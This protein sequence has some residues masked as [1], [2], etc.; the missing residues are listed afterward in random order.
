MRGTFIGLL[1]LATILGSVAPATASGHAMRDEPVAKI[2]QPAKAKLS[3]AGIDIRKEV[4]VRQPREPSYAKPWDDKDNLLVLDAY[5]FN[6]IDW[7][8]L[9][10]D[11][12]VVGFINKASD[13]LPEVYDCRN[14]GLNNSTPEHCRTRWRKYSVT[15]ELYRTRR[16]IAKMHGLK[17][18]AY[19]LGRPGNPEAQAD[20]FLDFAEPA[21]DE[22]IAID[23]EHND[24]EKWMS[25]EETERFARRVHQRIGRWPA[26]YT[27]ASTAKYIA[28]NRDKYRILSRLPL[29]YARFKEH[30]KGDFPMGHWESYHSWQFLAHINCKK[31]CAYRPKGTNKDIDVNV[32]NASIE[33]LDEMWATK[34]L[35][36]LRDG[37][38]GDGNTILVDGGTEVDATAVGSVT[39]AFAPG[40]AS[41]EK[42]RSVFGKV[43]SVEDSVKAKI[44]GAP[45]TVNGIPLPLT[46]P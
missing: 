12:R 10:Q 11:E 9:L 19:H 33:T 29:W 41:S 27:N 31:T 25:L 24:P 34:D 44:A 21:E 8:E 36:P 20:H 16:A 13:G 17:W 7:E 18:G 40:D 37:E 3:D 26:L 46:R 45:K 30:V 28:H 1:G 15:K 39:T 22:F 6:E 32:V 5:E 23:L 43:L 14:G 42:A 2:E 4:Q 35:V 38:G